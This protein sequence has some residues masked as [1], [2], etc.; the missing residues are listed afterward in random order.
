MHNKTAKIYNNNL[1]TFQ[2][3]FLKKKHL[4]CMCSHKLNGFLDFV[5]A[6][7]NVLYIGIVLL[8]STVTLTVIKYVTPTVMQRTDLNSILY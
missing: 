6:T 8:L 2:I 4:K 5:S 7:Y 3:K 1:C